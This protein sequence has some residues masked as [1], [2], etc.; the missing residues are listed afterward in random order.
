M[1]RSDQHNFPRFGGEG[2]GRS[3]RLASW[4][5]VGIFLFMAFG[6]IAA[7]RDFLMPVTMALLL[8]FVFTPLRRFARR[9]G[10]PDALTALGVTLG[11]LF[12]VAV[13][14]YAAS[15]PISR[16][17]NNMPLITTQLEQ[18]FDDLQESLRDFQDAARRIDEAQRVEAPATPGEQTIRVEQE[19][20]STLQT[21]MKLTPLLLAQVLF[22]LVLLFFMM[23][24][25]DLLYL[26]IVQSFDRMREKRAAYLALREIED[27][28]GNYL[29]AITIINAGLGLAIGLAMWAWGMPAP[30][31][32]GLGAFVLNFIPYLGSITGV[33]ISGLVAMI[34]MP[35][36]FWPLM[37]ALTY[38]GLTSLEGQIVT[39]YFVSRRLQMN[40]VV[41]FLAVA[42]WAY[43]WSV[44]GMVIAVPVLV[45]LRVLAD[46]VPGWERFG[47]FLAGEDPP[48]LEDD[49]EEEAR[50]VVETGA[51][52]EDHSAAEAVTRPLVEGDAPRSQ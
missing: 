6:A 35:G 41:V 13:L 34:V 48:A 49:D 23:A 11:I 52:A 28:L 47:N 50:E 44:I 3:P 29:G 17:M 9:Y 7:A 32:F 20:E 30:L 31:L 15:G 46:H 10:V 22:T 8:F 19:G 21:V 27:S 16:A 1:A 18:K 26:K 14:A 45:V 43:L 24:S 40:T 25:G 2:S 5:V 4:A 36:L 33:A 51:E 12:S 37:V 39:P 42:F 38:L